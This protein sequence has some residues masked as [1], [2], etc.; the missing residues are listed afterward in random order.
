MAA[1]VKTGQN[2]KPSSNASSGNYKKVAD[3]LIQRLLKEGF[4][5]QRYDAY[6]T[7][8]IYL[9][10]DYGVANSLRISDHP[11]KNHLSYRFNLIRGIHNYYVDNGGKYPRYYY[12]FSRV[13]QLIQDVL[14]HRQS[15]I[16]QYGEQRYK[17][18]MEKNLSNSK[19]EEG[20]W[21]KA[22]LVSI[23]CK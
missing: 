18:F 14:Q 11:G 6:S 9:K 7:K 17:Q 8:S 12:S 15:R 20:F 13:N 10:L 22:V 5:I 2:R 1:D 19:D 3:K 23:E 4:T 21:K 16:D